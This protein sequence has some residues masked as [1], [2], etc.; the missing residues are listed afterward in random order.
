MVERG[1]ITMFFLAKQM[2]TYTILFLAGLVLTS[3]LGCALKDT[4]DTSV[5]IIALGAKDFNL[6]C[7]SSGAPIRITSHYSG[8]SG[9]NAHVITNGTIVFFVSGNTFNGIGWDSEDLSVGG[10]IIDRDLPLSG[11]SVVGRGWWNDIVKRDERFTVCDNQ[12]HQGQ[13]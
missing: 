3:F 12:G 6:T 9:E 11:S 2:T 7:P 8:A 5:E 13:H 4:D 1:T 10:H